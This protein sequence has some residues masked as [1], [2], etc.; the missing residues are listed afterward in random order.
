M[1]RIA[2]IGKQQP[3][4]IRENMKRMMEEAGLSVDILNM[5][6]RNTADWKE[7]LRPYAAVISAG[8]AFPAETIAALDNLELIS[9]FGVGTNEIDKAYAAE[10]GV[11]VCNAAG[12]FSFCVAEC[13][14]SL[15]LN[16]LR[17]FVN[18]EKD[19]RR[20]DWS[21]F[22][23]GR[24][25]RQLSGKTVGLI[26]FG[27]ISQALA[28]ILRGFR[29]NILAYDIRKNEEAA[30]RLGVTFCEMDELIAKSDVISLHLPLTPQ[31]KHMIDGNFIA[32]MKPGAILVNTSR[33]G[34]IQ[35]AEVAAALNEGRLT[36]FGTDVFSVEPPPADNPILSAKNTMLLP[37][38]GSNGI[39]SV[40]YA[41]EYA[42]R[43]VIDFFTGKT[44][45]TILNPDYVNHKPID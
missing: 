33:G 7:E 28:E 34:L 8:E 4:Y 23:E 29:C 24:N 19:L 36:A 32:K 21:R 38:S 40:E 39:E 13:A 12:S 20:G 18:A 44:V 42:A 15:I 2:I 1:K 30:K 6:T 25:A 27:D 3:L 5:P 10:H 45:K 35:E 9:R 16:L 37:H 43:N 17:D 41:G 22:F 11:A 14:A 31:T 26:G